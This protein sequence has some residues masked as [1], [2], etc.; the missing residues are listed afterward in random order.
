MTRKLRIVS[1]LTNLCIGG[2]PNRL[3]AFSRALDRSRFEHTVLV[4]ADPMDKTHLALGP[5]LPQ[6]QAFGIAVES[7]HEPPRAEQRGSGPAPVRAL[8]ELGALLRI[9]RRL[10]CYFIEHETDVIDARMSY[11]VMFGAVAGRLAGVPVIVAT[12]YG[13]GF[14]QGPLLSLAGQAAY[15]LADALVSDSQAKVAEH[16]DWLWRRGIE[17]RVIPNGIYRPQ[18]QRT[19]NEMRAWLKLPDNPRQRVIGQVS[20]ILPSKGHSVLIEAARRVIEADPDVVFVICGYAHSP[21]YV[22]E[23]CARAAALGI[24][25]HV[26][27]VSYPGPVAD[28]WTVIDIHVHASLLDSA[29]IAIH[30]SLALGLPSVVTRVGG[31]ADQVEDQVTSLVVE[32]C[33][34]QALAAALVRVLQEPGLAERMGTAA[35][36]RHDRLCQPATMARAIENLF[37]ELFNA[38]A[39]G[40]ALPVVDS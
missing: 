31:I 3:L 20:R 8:R 6:F 17:T 18:A 28:I 24:R 34:A 25:D 5:L 32:P 27:I 37:V 23:L 4:I 11:A 29:P 16:L 39:R 21:A 12:E 9:V 33:D 15:V 2:D 13:P 1:L 30:E 38:S 10:R 36:R 22:D 14:W 7:L 19:R 40:L 35:R 26:F